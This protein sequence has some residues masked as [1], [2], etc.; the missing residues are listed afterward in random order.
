VRHVGQMVERV[1]RLG[2]ASMR[3]VGLRNVVGT[4]RCMPCRVV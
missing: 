1:E 3:K 4:R 2:R